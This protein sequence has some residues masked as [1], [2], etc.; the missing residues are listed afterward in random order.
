MWYL[1]IKAYVYVIMT[2]QRDDELLVILT[3][4]SR[5]RKDSNAPEE[6]DIPLDQN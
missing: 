5:S 6:I 3:P 4:I 2:S 1:I